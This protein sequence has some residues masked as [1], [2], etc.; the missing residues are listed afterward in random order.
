MPDIDLVQTGVKGLDPLFAGGIPRAN[1][2]IL[3]GSAVSKTRS[4]PIT[5][6]THEVEIL[7][8]QGMRVLPRALDAARPVVPFAGYH[9]LISRSPERRPLWMR[10]QADVQ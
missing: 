7:D 4:S 9:G 8:G 10:T 2:V 3:T 1:I 6:T 5:R